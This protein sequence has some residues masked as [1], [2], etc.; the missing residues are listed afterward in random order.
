[1]ILEWPVDHIQINGITEDKMLKNMIMHYSRKIRKLTF[2]PY[3][4][5]Y[6]NP[7]LTTDGFQYLTLLHPYLTDLTLYNLMEGGLPII[8]RSLISL[9]SLAILRSIK[10]LSDDIVSL[11][12]LTNLEKITFSSVNHLNEAALCLIPTL[13]KLKSIKIEDCGGLSGLGLSRLLINNDS[14]AELELLNC[15]CRDDELSSEE[16]HC[17]STLTNL[18]KLTL[19]GSKLDDIG[20]NMI[21]SHCLLIEHLDIFFVP[22][23]LI[24]EEGLNN[25]HHLS[26]LSYLGL[27]FKNSWLAKLSHNS[28]L[29]H[30]DLSY[31]D[32]SDEGLSFLSSLTN[33]TKLDLEYCN[34]T[35][36]GLSF[37]SSL[38]NLKSLDLEC[39]KKITDTGLLQFS[40]LINFTVLGR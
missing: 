22:N 39:C 31:S 1:M 27:C 15:W 33:L 4:A 34:I 38:A 29:V 16:F 36:E 24:T 11:S 18:T 12:K 17:L 32:V 40:S 14:I 26:H 3:G 21:C 8:S 10:V 37:L 30:L 7:R 5:S 23:D 28:S 35:D 25:I 9:T 6:T 20:L 13:T 2:M 19:S